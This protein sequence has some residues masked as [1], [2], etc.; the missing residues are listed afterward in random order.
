MTLNASLEGV[1]KCCCYL[2][3]CTLETAVTEDVEL[4]Y[5]SEA[6]EVYYM[7][8]FILKQLR[9][10]FMSDFPLWGKSRTNAI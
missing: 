7:H 5:I 3:P 2:T 4:C 10:R 1:M 9:C 8:S 6:T